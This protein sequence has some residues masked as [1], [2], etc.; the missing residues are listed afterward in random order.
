MK[1]TPSFTSLYPGQFLKQYFLHV[2]CFKEFCC[3]FL[4]AESSVTV[5]VAQFLIKEAETALFSQLED[6]LGETKRDN[7]ILCLVN[8]ETIYC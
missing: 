1:D 6:S 7:K 2:I 4:V 3:H 5:K 8:T